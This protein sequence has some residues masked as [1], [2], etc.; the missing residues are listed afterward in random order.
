MCRVGA[1]CARTCS[2]SVPPPQLPVC[3]PSAVRMEVKQ[4]GADGV[5]LAREGWRPTRVHYLRE[6]HHVFS[7]PTF[8]LRLRGTL[9]EVV[10]L[11][12]KKTGHECAT[13]GLKAQV[14]IDSGAIE[15]VLDQL[16]Y[17][18]A[19]VGVRQRPGRG[20]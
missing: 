3:L 7:P 20:E 9:S 15:I 13:G 4:E 14:E 12:H 5:V 16:A 18:C 6:L 10:F 8:A 17:G 11:R 2:S 19:R 1:L